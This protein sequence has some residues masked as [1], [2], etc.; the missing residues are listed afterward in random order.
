MKDS[1]IK[2]RSLLGRLGAGH[3]AA[4]L[5]ALAPLVYF[6]SP[7]H[8]GLVLC[9][10]D[11]ITFN[12]PLR[13]A[14]ARIVADAHLPLWNPY[15]F[16][17]MPLL[18][19]VQG[20]IL[21]PLNWFFL[22]FNA[23]TAMNLAMYSTYALAGLGAYL[24][25]RR[26]GANIAGA[27]A[28][29]F[30]WQFS[31]FL[32]AQIGHTNVI[33]TACLLPWLLWTMDGYAATRRRVWGA[34]LACTVALQTFAGHPQTLAYSLLLAAAYAIFMA[35]RREHVERRRP[36]LWSLLLM[37]TGVTL[38]AVQILPTLELM[39]NSVR[40]EA[41]YDFFSSFSMPPS[42]LLTYFAPYILGGGD[43]TLFRA[44]YTGV[45]FYGEYI[46][47]VGVAALA[48]ACLAP[49]IRRD[50]RTKFWTVAAL[51]ALALALG[52]FW[53]YDL[54]QLVYHIPVLNLFR[55]PARH[56]MELDF[57][58][59][60]LVGRAITA[61]AST[62]KEKRTTFAALAV[63]A[64]VFVLT[65]LVVT[66]WRPA[67]FQLGRPALKVSFLRAPELFLPVIVAA[68]GLW[69][70]WRF[71][72]GRRGACVLLLVV[73]VVDLSLW[74]QMSG[75]R[76]TS[77]YWIDNFW[78]TPTTVET[79]RRREGG[80]DGRYRILTFRETFNPDSTVISSKV[81]S[82]LFVMALQ[83]NT[84]MMYGVENAAGYDGFGLARQS[85][86]ADGMKLW[87]DLDAPE[88]TLRESR[89]L[90]L[91]NVRYLFAH[92]PD[93]G[94]DAEPKQAA[95]R[96]TKR[97]GDF[98][99]AEEN[100][101]VPN[102]EEGARLAFVTPRVEANRIALVTSLTWSVEM[103]DGSTVGRVRL[104]AED[105]RTFEFPVLAG[106]DTSEW[107]HDRKILRE[108]V[109]HR[110]APVAT[111]FEVEDKEGNYQGHAYVA[112]FVL[113]E[114]VFIT[115][116]SIEVAVDTRA[117]K[118][119]LSVQR[120]SLIDDES[121]AALPL[122][123]AWFTKALPS[124][125]EGQLAAQS[126]IAERWRRTTEF[127]DVWLYENMRALPRVW[128]ATESVQMKDD[129]LLEV[130][131]TGKL[132]D[133]HAWEPRRTV[134]HDETLATQ[135]V[136][137]EAIETRA[138]ITRYEPNRID[139]RAETPVP[140]MLVLSENHYPGWRAS[141]DGRDVDI[142]R[143]NYNQRGIMLAP[144]THEVRF[145]YRP[146]SVLYGF[147]V[148]VLMAAVLSIWWLGFGSKEGGWRRV[149]ERLVG[150]GREAK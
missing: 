54:Y 92:P 116:G 15:L 107:S 119:G 98:L 93:A 6:F 51:V 70:L 79:L 115:G 55:V 25:A 62:H 27:I 133:T 140:S 58:L 23:P 99:F 134:L 66:V 87:G 122:R 52:R 143:V 145:V 138:E 29:G 63:G 20:G 94:V 76:R 121:G 31:G 120:V 11:C 81:D 108:S 77:P 24:Y 71:A 45:A 33:Q 32:V 131:R 44:P 9:S 14:A 8:G 150:R 110:R 127:E 19:A 46:G 34:T 137:T 112:S 80:D 5:V 126:S 68:L 85:R 135:L 57:A 111:N 149:L 103:P 95:L 129:A 74:G 30:I 4:L 69:A 82:L 48:L 144:G 12:L 72:R 146:K 125:S 141:V 105:G 101:G 47:Y 16:G 36:Y 50:A 118:L 91:F 96:A 39:H 41:S 147:L 37:A 88:Q 59:A 130:I 42:F 1:S 109:R 132:D 106:R 139:V 113:P 56:L 78:D 148:S 73:I 64:I 104:R 67:D 97:L 2:I 90:D 53:P 49:I 35:T 61:I 84:Y 75:W 7:A 124:Q 10:G 65:C 40:A 38:A 86:M 123:K 26:T 136:G 117:P 28:T 18:A 3:A 13:V 17:G 128:L 83:H 21:L 114:K 89:A 22:V 43:R 102:L 100:I 142:L 60:V